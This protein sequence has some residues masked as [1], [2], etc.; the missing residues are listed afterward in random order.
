MQIVNS[1]KI[2]EQVVSF[3]GIGTKFTINPQQSQQKSNGRCE[4]SFFPK[5]REGISVDDAVYLNFLPQNHVKDFVLHNTISI[6]KGF[7]S[8]V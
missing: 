2:T 4:F 7:P 5:T 6:Q 1:D 3:E 8:N